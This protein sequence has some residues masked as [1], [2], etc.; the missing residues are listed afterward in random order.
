MKSQCGDNPLKI[1]GDFVCLLGVAS[2]AS[3]NQIRF[4]VSPTRILGKDM[5]NG[6]HCLLTPVLYAWFQ[7]R[8]VAIEA[9][10]RLM[11]PDTFVA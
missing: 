7:H 9:L 11:V 5:V 6:P 1:I 8:Y 10:S 4:V 3:I 2:L